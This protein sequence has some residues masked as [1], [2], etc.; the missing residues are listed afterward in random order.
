VIIDALPSH[1]L[2]RAFPS[3]RERS[4]RFEEARALIRALFTADSP[5]D[6]DGR[7]YQ[8]R[9]APQSPECFQHPHIPIL[10]G[11][12]GER[13]TLRTLAMYGDIFNLD[14]WARG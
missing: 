3:M 4:D 5:V 8:L 7:Y 6:Y 2:A 1:K 9:Q 14:S 11:G 10:V 13:R 12:T